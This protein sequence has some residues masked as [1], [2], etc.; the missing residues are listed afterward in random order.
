MHYLILT[1]LHSSSQVTMV[2]MDYSSSL[3]WKDFDFCKVLTNT[4]YSLKKKSS[5]GTLLNILHAAYQFQ[6][7]SVIGKRSLIAGDC[8]YSAC[9]SSGKDSLTFCFFP[10]SLFYTGLKKSALITLLEEGHLQESVMASTYSLTREKDLNKCLPFHPFSHSSRSRIQLA[11]TVLPAI[12]TAFT[13][14]WSQTG[15]SL[16]QVQINV[17]QPAALT[18]EK[19]P[20][21][22]PGRE[23]LQE[24]VKESTFD[25]KGRTKGTNWAKY[26]RPHDQSEFWL[27]KLYFTP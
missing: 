2:C 27:P 12:L 22:K 25:F 21:S 15:R 19:L 10:M 26:L 24:G 4:K 6:Y 1:L 17:W 20:A 18:C 5:R 3:G 8:F 14:P 16:L 13:F 11:L 23:N 9:Y 7:C